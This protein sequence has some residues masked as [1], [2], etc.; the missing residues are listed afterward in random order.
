MSK[1][2]ELVYVADPMCSWCWGFSPVVKSIVNHF[3][4]RAPVAVIAGGLA[5]DTTEPMDERA[6]SVVREHWDHVHEATGQPFDYGFFER[7]QFVYNTEL[8]CRALISAR[9]LQPDLALTFLN[10]LHAAFYRDNR[11]ITNAATLCDLA[12]TCGL[13]P[14]QFAQALHGEETLQATQRDFGLSRAMGIIGFPSLIG[15]DG[16]RLTVI[17]I[18]YRPWESVERFI[19]MWLTTG[20][21][22][23]SSGR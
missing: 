1:A 10:H 5:P 12:V 9:M 8:P 15:N 7:H 23:T 2:N 11:D 20:I 22:S 21:K 4:D 3:A 16:E 13:D 14:G 18:G 19:D 6:R 17:S